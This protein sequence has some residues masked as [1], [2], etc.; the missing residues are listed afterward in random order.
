LYSEVE[1]K[2]KLEAEK[3]EKTQLDQA[4]NAPSLSISHEL[5]CHGEF[6]LDFCVG[7]VLERGRF[8]VG[9]VRLRLC[10]LFFF[11]PTKLMRKLCLWQELVQHKLD[12]EKAKADLEQVRLVLYG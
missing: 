8:V 1:L 6:D 10:H 2:S 4:S 3:A 7:L 9:F 12:R 11:N 5:R